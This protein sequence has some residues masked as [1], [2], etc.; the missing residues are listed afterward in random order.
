MNLLSLSL[1][2]LLAGFVAQEAVLHL[3][4]A[5]IRLDLAWLV[6]IFLGFFVNLG[7]GGIAVFLIGLAQESLGA[8]GHGSLTLSY[9][10][11]FMILR[12]T[13]Q[14][15]FF[16]GG[17]SQAIWVMILTILQ[18]ALEGL[19]IHMH[20]NEFPYQLAGD[21]LYLLGTAFLQGLASLF[22]FPILKRGIK[23]TE[24]YGT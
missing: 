13:H 20:G 6:V 1:G 11:I 23:R 16:Q 18:K 24:R 10:A 2:V 21:W 9:L 15:L 4:L 7:P 12:L 14:N 22:V 8:G 19:L 5:F 3:P 17:S